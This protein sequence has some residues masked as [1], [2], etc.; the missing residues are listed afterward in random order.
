[1]AVVGPRGHLE[2]RE[3]SAG[4]TPPSFSVHVPLSGLDISC[5]AASSNGQ[6]GVHIFSFF[7]GLAAVAL[8]SFLLCSAEFLWFLLGISR[9][10]ISHIDH[11]LRRPHGR[12][13]ALVIQ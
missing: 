4:L 10:L 11:G 5:L 9:L 3:A 7:F 2:V 6:V 1:M 13:Y 8:S 12:S